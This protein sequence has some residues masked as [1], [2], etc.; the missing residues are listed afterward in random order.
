V[1][2]SCIADPGPPET[3]AVPGLQR[4]TPVRCAR[5]SVS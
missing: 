5:D 2:E 1:S 4:T 3:A